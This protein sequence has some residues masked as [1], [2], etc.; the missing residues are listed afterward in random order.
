MADWKQDLTTFFTCAG[1]VLAIFI[2]D[3]TLFPYLTSATSPIVL[4]LNIFGFGIIVAVSF[5]I[6]HRRSPKI[7][8]RKAERIAIRYAQEH[9]LASDA[10]LYKQR[11]SKLVMDCWQVP[12]WSSMR[13]GSSLQSSNK[14]RVDV[15]QDTGKIASCIR[16]DR[17][18]ATLEEEWDS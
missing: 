14:Y 9:L 17:K 3:A 8:R 11:P 6:W 12:I 13:Q 5:I 1:T 15:N 4:W 7:S 2:V 16:V 18:P 10:Q